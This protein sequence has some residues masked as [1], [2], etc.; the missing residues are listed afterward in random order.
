MTFKIKTVF[1]EQKFAASKLIVDRL[2][3]TFIRCLED[4]APGKPT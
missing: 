2:V 3:D 1:E 4:I